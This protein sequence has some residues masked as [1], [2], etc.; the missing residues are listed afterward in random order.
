VNVKNF[1]HFILFLTFTIQNANIPAMEEIHNIIKD[2]RKRLGI[3]QAAFAEL[4]SSTRENVAKYETGRAMPPGDFALRVINLN[5]EG[6]K[7]V[8]RK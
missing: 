8:I 3:T 6:T 1:I 4:L 2:T 7:N 5:K